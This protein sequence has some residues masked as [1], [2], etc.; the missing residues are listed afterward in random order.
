MAKLE[1]REDPASRFAEGRG[2][3]IRADDWRDEEGESS[4]SRWSFCASAIAMLRCLYD[5]EL[6]VACM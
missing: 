2:V 6:R 1:E 4:L 5:R 3:G